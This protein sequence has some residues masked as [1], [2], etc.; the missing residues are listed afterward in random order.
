MQKKQVVTIL[1]RS[2]VAL[3]IPICGQLFV[4]GWNWG[5]GEFVF[6]WAFFNVL[7]LTTTFVTNR[8]P[9]RAGKIAAGACVVVLFAL[10]WVRLATG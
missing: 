4:E 6:A 7:G 1:I 9:R 5:L 10:I 8:I 2:T 3:I